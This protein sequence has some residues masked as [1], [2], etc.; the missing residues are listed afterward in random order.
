M[1][2]L[3]WWDT[4]ESHV[5]TP[6]VMDV[7]SASFPGLLSQDG[8]CWWLMRN[9]DKPP[10]FMVSTPA[11]WSST[12]NFCCTPLPQVTCSSCVA[13]GASATLA[14]RAASWGMS[15]WCCWVA[16]H[17]NVGLGV[18]VKWSVMDKW[19]FSGWLIRWSLS[20]LNIKSENS[21]GKYWRILKVS[22]CH[23]YVLLSFVGY[24]GKVSTI[25]SHWLDDQ[26]VS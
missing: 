26:V 22:M 8:P 11:F 24:L 2:Y 25:L 12:T 7:L 4:W 3:W 13:R 15:W 17:G 21:G 16:S 10:F 9:H 23:K 5:K 6:E 14:T 1:P 20:C 18:G 19:W